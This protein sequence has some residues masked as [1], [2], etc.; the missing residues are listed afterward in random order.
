MNSGDSRAACAVSQ[1][2]TYADE[3]QP[4]H[5][6]D[7]ATATNSQVPE[8][9]L[10]FQNLRIRAYPGAPLALTRDHKPGPAR[11]YIEAAGGCVHPRAFRTP[12]HLVLVGPDRIYPGGLAVARGLGDLLFKDPVYLRSLG[13]VRPLVVADPEILV[14]PTPIVDFA[15]VGCD[16]LWDVFST[17]EAIRLARVLL[18]VFYSQ[19]PVKRDVVR[20]LGLEPE[21]LRLASVPQLVA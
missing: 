6:F 18:V 7:D 21:R 8:E 14:I 4:D 13:V 15:L 2:L 19:S 12:G 1:T 17:G 16:G 5:F 20:G 11:A 9:N 10:Q 3:T